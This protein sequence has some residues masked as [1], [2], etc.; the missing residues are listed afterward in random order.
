MGW[1]TRRT[2]PLSPFHLIGLT[3]ICSHVATANVLL[4]GTRLTTLIGL[5]KN[6]VAIGAAIRITRINGWTSREQR[7]RLCRS[8]IIPQRAEFGVGVVQI[9]R[10]VK[11][12]GAVAAHIVA[13]RRHSAVAVPTRRAVRDN[14]VLESRRSID[15]AT[16]AAEAAVRAIPT[17][18]AVANQR[19]TTGADTAADCV[20]AGEVGAIP[21]DG[22]VANGQR[23]ATINAASFIGAIPAD[24]AV[25][26]GQHRI[27]ED[28]ARIGVAR[29]SAK[30]TGRG[31][32]PADGAVG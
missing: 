25:A 28:A 32:I 29:F 12:T 18:G 16:G 15:A 13:I 21:A 10:A 1:R 6:P 17:D 11:I 14:A 22:A 26:D 2:R 4:V 7:D 5:Q 27:I 31:G 3:F 23:P 20:A 24:G 30:T 9:A 19:A 8:A